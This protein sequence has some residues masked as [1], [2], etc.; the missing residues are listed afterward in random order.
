MPAI[1]ITLGWGLARIGAIAALPAVLQVLEENRQRLEKA[2]PSRRG[3]FTIRRLVAFVIVTGVIYGSLVLIDR[4]VKWYRHCIRRAD[5]H[6]AA[7]AEMELMADG[8]RPSRGFHPYLSAKYKRVADYHALMRRKWEAAARAPAS[9]WHPTRPSRNK[10]R[11][12]QGC[13]MVG[14]DAGSGSRGERTR[15]TRGPAEAETRLGLNED[16]DAGTESRRVL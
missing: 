14:A 1:A 15:I 2:V 3:Q 10:L 16:V 4:R 7:Q 13:S 11:R 12:P 5:Q 9:Q 8:H 6:Q